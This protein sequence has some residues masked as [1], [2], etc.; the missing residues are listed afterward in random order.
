M[1]SGIGNDLGFQVINHKWLF[2]IVHLKVDASIFHGHLNRAVGTDS[3]VR[4][5]SRGC[6]TRM[7]QKTFD[8]PSPIAGMDDIETGSF[9]I[10]A[11]QNQAA[12]PEAFPTKIA[13]YL[14]DPGKRL[15][16]K[17]RVLVNQ[18]IPGGETG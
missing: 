15:N 5:C 8:I 16:S 1:R 4:E 2:D 12:L 14:L 6:I 7:G 17:A 3:A 13:V 11:G 9:K 18:H 10:E